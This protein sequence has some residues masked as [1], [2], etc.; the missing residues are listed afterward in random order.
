MESTDVVS[1]GVLEG[2]TQVASFATGDPAK[3]ADI[4]SL[5]TLRTLE[6]VLAG[7]APVAYIFGHM[8]SG[9]TSKAHLFA[10]LFD[11]VHGGTEK[12]TQI[13]HIDLASNIR[14]SEQATHINNFGEVKRWF[15]ENTKHV[16]GTEVARE[17]TT[18]KLYILD[19]ASSSAGGSGRQGHEV[20]KKMAPLVYAVRKSNGALIVI[21]HD[22]KDVAPVFRALGT[23]FKAHKDDQT[24]LTIAEDVKDREVRDVVAEVK[25]V[26]DTD[27][28][29]N[30]GEQPT[31]S[32]HDRPHSG[33]ESESWD[34]SDLEDL[35]DDV[36]KAE[37]KLLVHRLE[38]A[39]RDGLLDSESGETPSQEQ[40]AI[41]VGIAQS[42]WSTWFNEVERGDDVLE[43]APVSLEQ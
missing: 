43:D 42:T 2:Q 32:W 41:G 33:G 21:G 1:R 7:R 6:S 18:P 3:R 39:R 13:T 20:R 23:I 5:R 27:L 37:K 10:Q 19:E 34:V 25:G 26:P 35:A 38:D 4:S 9:K 36:S 40:L 14:S 8:G 22:G 15:K 28:S 24:K 11:R 31:F 29:Y 12:P 16:D 30:D 17:D